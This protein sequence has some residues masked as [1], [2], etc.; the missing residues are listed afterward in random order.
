MRLRRV[1]LPAPRK[2][3]RMV[4]GIGDIGFA[5]RDGWMKPKIMP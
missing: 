4:V 2:P 5:V 1:V 3:V